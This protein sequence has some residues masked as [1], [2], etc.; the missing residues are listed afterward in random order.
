LAAG[1]WVDRPS[2]L[3][4][5]LDQGAA[6]EVTVLDTEVMVTEPRT[7]T[8]AGEGAWANRPGRGAAGMAGGEAGAAVA[9]GAAGGAGGAVGG[10][11][12]AGDRAA[13]PGARAQAGS[14]AGSEMEA[15]SS[16]PSGDR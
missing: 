9:G 12:G 1:F 8:L 16:G 3:A 4:A 15:S 7:G 10:G 13:G 11:I 14:G 2:E 5:S 6:I